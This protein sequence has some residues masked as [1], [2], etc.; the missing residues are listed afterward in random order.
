MF[1][2]ARKVMVVIVR[3]YMEM[4]RVFLGMRRMMAAARAR[5]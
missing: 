4:V 3:R 2:R 5:K 1:L